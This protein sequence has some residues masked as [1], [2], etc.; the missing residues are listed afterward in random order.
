MAS[1]CTARLPGGARTGLAFTSVRQL[2]TAMGQQQHYTSMCEA[3][4]RAALAPVGV[5]HIQVDAEFVGA[6]VSRLPG[7]RP[8]GPVSARRQPTWTSHADAVA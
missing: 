4:L 7:L 6:A 8:N 1:I 3:A 5:D 2:A